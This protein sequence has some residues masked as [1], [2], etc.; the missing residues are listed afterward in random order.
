MMKLFRQLLSGVFLPRRVDQERAY[1]N[2]SVSIT[3]LERRQR[4]IEGGLFRR[5]GFA[6][7]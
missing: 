2:A 1:L 5:T 3:D 7:L 6:H 4:E